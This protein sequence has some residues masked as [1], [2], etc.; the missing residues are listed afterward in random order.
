MLLGVIV[1]EAPVSSPRSTVFPSIGTGS[2]N[3]PHFPG[4][5]VTLNTGTSIHWWREC[6]TARP[7][8]TKRTFCCL[9]L[10]FSAADFCFLVVFPSS[11]FCH[12]SGYFFAIDQLFNSHDSWKCKLN[13]YQTSGWLFQHLGSVTPTWFVYSCFCDPKLCKVTK[14]TSMQDAWVKP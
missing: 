14:V 4:E 3:S 1:T 11:G 2:V 12:L 10:F 6:L 13:E 8:L 7:S 9:F 5:S